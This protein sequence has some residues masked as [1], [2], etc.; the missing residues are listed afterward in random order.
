[1]RILLAAG[2]LTHPAFHEAKA[3]EPA[4]SFVAHKPTIVWC[5]DTDRAWV[6]G[7]SEY[8]GC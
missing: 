5:A 8:P 3:L 7:R 6:L 2:A 4:A 1:M